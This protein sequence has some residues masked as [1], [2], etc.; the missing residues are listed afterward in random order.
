MGGSE[1]IG[2]EESDAVGKVI[3]DGVPFRYGFDEKRR[4]VFKVAEFEKR[5]ADYVGSRY[6][7]AVS[8]GS[9][10][11][12]VALAAIGVGGG[13]EVITQAFTF[14]ATVEAIVASG[15][16]PVLCEVD[17]TLN[18]DPADLEK[19][20]TDKTKVVIPVHMLGSPARMNEI[21]RVVSKHRLLLLEDSCQACGSVYKGRKTG[22]IGSLGAFSFDYVKTI[23][24]G[25]G[26]MLVT[27]E[28]EF[29]L[30][31]SEYHDHGHKHNPDVPRGEDSKGIAG[32]N[33]RM[34]DIQGAIG[35][36]QL[37]RLDFVLSQQ[38]KHKT[39]I[40]SAIK[41]IDSIEFRELTD[42]DGDGADTLIFFLPDKERAKRFEG[43]L[44]GDNI[45]TKILPSALGWHF[46]GYWAHMSAD[47]SPALWPKTDEL[48]N[49]AIAIPISVK[50]TDADIGKIVEGIHKAAKV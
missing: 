8:S 29:Y 44:T 42:E 36:V 16:K 34:S 7:L 35:V 40:K 28:E 49:R 6:T 1:L 50:M 3:T 25:E 11:L 26:G 38:R 46:A 32:F 48:L 20:I 23:T 39:A 21:G 22:T 19:K 5:F 9:A 27:D 18:L 24:T 4:G 45:P 13:D 15:A 43:S 37:G 10:T 14:V 17:K 47:Y 12:R 30:R 41:D 33:Y 31:A 2:K